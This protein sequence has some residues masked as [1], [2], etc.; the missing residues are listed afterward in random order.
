[1]GMPRRGLVDVDTTLVEL[2]VMMIGRSGGPDLAA[3]IRIQPRD[4]E[5]RWGEVGEVFGVCVCGVGG[6]R[7]YVRLGR[8]L[9]EY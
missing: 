8:D 2:R 1:M 3:V 9:F 6:S 7:A 5:M 4:G